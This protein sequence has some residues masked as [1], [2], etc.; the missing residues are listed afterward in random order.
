MFIVWIDAA[1]GAG[2]RVFGLTLLE[3]HLKA[4]KHRKLQPGEVIID[5]GESAAD[6]PPEAKRKWPFPLRVVRHGGTIA[7][8]IARVAGGARIL[9]L[10]AQ[11]LVDAR[12][13]DFLVQQRHDLVAE[14]GDA[15]IAWIGDP[16]LLDAN[17]A[18]LRSAVSGSLPRLTQAEFPGFIRNLR[19]TLPF[20]LFRIGSVE[21]RAK[22][23]RFLF[24]SNYK[25]ST[26]FFTKYVYPP[27]V[28]V[29]VRPLAHAHVH[30]NWVTIISIILTF[31]AVPLFGGG[32]FLAGFLCAYG[33]S[34]LDSV[35][36][37]LARLTFTDSK[38]GNVL[39]HGL[40]LVHP[41]FWYCAWAYGLSQGD[42]WSPVFLAS[43][44]M[45]L[46]YMVDR[47]IL[48]IYPT[49]F[50]RG[51]HTHG[52]MD[53]FVRTFISRRN[54][55]LPLFTVGYIAGF[56]IETIY[57]IVAWQAATCLY[58]GARTAWILAYDRPAPAGSA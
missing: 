9:A 45:L 40:D 4:L 36:G 50:G 38:I 2:E 44:V 57:L 37:K 27:L 58:H 29:M 49:R 14:D 23:E 31:A 19:R 48:K 21:D 22:V 12:L 10:D 35:D 42:V 15:A 3:R 55:N 5:L 47:L 34:V 46:L 20:Y 43:L 56:G 18:D 17:A 7:Q 16:I 51:L 54:I 30:P 28:W 11:T 26:D 33:M 32:Y 6:D 1:R 52:P 13:Y 8:R 25:G 53:G 41:P 24:W 39:D